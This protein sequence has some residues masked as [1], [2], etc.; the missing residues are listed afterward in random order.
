MRKRDG[1]WI[2]GGVFLLDRISKILSFRLPP[3]GLTL[4]PGVIRLRLTRNDGAAFSLLRGAPWLLGV[5][6]LVILLAAAWLLRKKRFSPLLTTG[7]ML[8]AGGAAGNM[9]DRFFTGFVPDMVEPLFVSFAVF[10]LADAA[11]TVGCALV[12]GSLLF[13]RPEEKPREPEKKPREPE[14]IGNDGKKD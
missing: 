7:I 4:I 6:S 14:E 12:I 11:L 1:L 2:A 10:N 5:I 3:E 8:M 13:G 9:A